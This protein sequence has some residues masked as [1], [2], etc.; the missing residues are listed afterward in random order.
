VRDSWTICR[1]CTTK[2]QKSKSMKWS[3][4][5]ELGLGKRLDPLV[6]LIN[7]YQNRYGSIPILVSMFGGCS[8]GR[9]DDS[10]GMYHQQKAKKQVLNEVERE[11]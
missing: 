4:R 3:E 7:R 5:D 6:L 8:E 1:V 11:G 10:P 2:R 9:L